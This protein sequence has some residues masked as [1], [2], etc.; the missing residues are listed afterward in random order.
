MKVLSHIQQSKQK[1]DKLFALLIDPDHHSAEQIIPSIEQ[2]VTCGVDLFFV[3]GS[4]LMNDSLARCV[5]LVKQRSDKPVVL[6]PG[7]QLQVD[8]QADALLLL[9]VIS[10]R[11][12]EMLIGRH[13]LAAPRLKASGLELIATGYILVDSGRPTTASYMS[14]TMPIP[15]NKPDIAACTAMAGEQL[16]LKCIFMDGGSGA[17]NPISDEMIAAVRS[18]IELPLIV[19]GG[20][21]SPE[22]VRSKFEA[23][24]DVVVVGNALEKDPALMADL[25]MAARF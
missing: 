24:A 16:G 10:G 15:H 14:G 25:V 17:L 11:N 2:A 9:S 5:D 20:L 23:G 12:P 18:S 8:A 6:F 4:L 7:D 1:G 13:V 22:A 3:G 19:G 21:R